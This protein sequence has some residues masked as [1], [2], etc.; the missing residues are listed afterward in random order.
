MIK[1]AGN[2]LLMVR[3]EV[4]YERSYFDDVTAYDN[5]TKKNQFTASAD[6][7]LRF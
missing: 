6:A 4:R 2:D 3:P 1:L 5:G 7:I